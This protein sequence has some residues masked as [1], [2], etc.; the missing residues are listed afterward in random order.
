MEGCAVFH[1]SRLLCLAGVLVSA[2][3][4]GCTRQPNPRACP[5]TPCPEGQA[6]MREGAVARCVA[7]D[8]GAPRV[9]GGAVGGDGG[10]AASDG[11]ISI[12]SVPGPPARSLVPG[13]TR[14]SS[15]N[16]T[17]VKTL[18]ATPGR[19]TVG[20]SKSYR[21]VGGVAGSSHK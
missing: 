21:A 19:S 15:R 17:V 16:Y 9:D 11:P 10:D 20:T 8:G 14:A 5:N 1:R 7:N 6:C 2:I 18:S 12:G 13:G 3:V 4:G